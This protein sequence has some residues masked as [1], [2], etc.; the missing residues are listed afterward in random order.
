MVATS[1]PALLVSA[2]ASGQGKTTVV[3]A[4]AR[5]AVRSGR[6]VRV[7][8]TGPDFI[9]PM[10]LARAARQPAYQLDLWMGGLAHCRQLLCQASR[11]A[12]L[13]LIE[14]VMGLYDGTPSSADLAH[15]FNL[16]VA[17]V[18]DAQAMAHTFGAVALGLKAYRPDLSLHGVLANRVAGARHTAM[19]AQS[20]AGPAAAI[21]FLG[22]LPRDSG[23]AIPDRHLGLVQAEEI[24][25][26]DARLDRAADAI[27]TTLRLD[28]IPAASFEVGV[29]IAPPALL[30]GVRI[31][32]AHDAAFS[33]LYR[34]NLDLLESMGASIAYFSPLRC[35]SLPSA[36]AVYLPGGYP[37]L[38]AKR[39]SANHALHRS[40]HAHVAA[41]KPLLAECGGMMVLFEHLTDLQG[42]RHAMVGLLPGETS[43][44]STLQSL[45]L[46]AV[47]FDE[48]ELRGHSFHYS[49]MNTPL[50]PMRFGRTQSGQGEALFR[51]RGLTASYI[52]FYWPSNPRAAA[53]LFLPGHRS[54]TVS[55]DLARTANT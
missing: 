18:I 53:A 14:G 21:R 29:E 37:E 30:T 43:M 28:E 24:D 11:E 40:L 5:C 47:D 45:A 1:V 4:L 23:L 32:V 46:Q 8:K 31:A 33:F 3:A 50:T 27:A 48:G 34:A 39:L 44:H 22:A 25:D 20:L 13:V 54:K 17:L 9:D 49:R 42:H 15:T 16:P 51:E 35:E 7:F 55:A 38:H 6:R 52:H 12:D 19:L 36:D 2:P 41:G 10:I 26:L